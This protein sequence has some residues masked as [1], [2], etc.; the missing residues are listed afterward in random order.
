MKEIF[1]I[2]VLTLAIGYLWYDNDHLS[3]EAKQLQM[4]N[5]TLNDNLYQ[6]QLELLRYSFALEN[7]NKN[8]P[9]AAKEFNDYYEN[10]TE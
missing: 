5:D 10:E 3:S 8:N 4:Q 1:T 2:A 9:K 6:C 7:F